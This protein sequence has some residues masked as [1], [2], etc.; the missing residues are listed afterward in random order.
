MD[1]NYLLF[2]ILFNLCLLNVLFLDFINLLLEFNNNIN[3]IKIILMQN[4]S[5]NNNK[6]YNEICNLDCTLEINEIIYFYDNISQFKNTYHMIPNKIEKKNNNQ[7]L[8]YYFNEPINNN[9]LNITNTNKDKRIFTFDHSH[10]NLCE[11]YIIDMS[12]SLLSK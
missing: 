8:I 3:E 11:W 5:N 1:I 9:K 12:S 7:C 6:I 10:N 2:S 4:Y